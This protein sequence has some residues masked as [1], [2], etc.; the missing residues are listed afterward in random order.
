MKGEKGF[1]FN[2]DFAPFLKEK[3]LNI[4][5]EKPYGSGWYSDGVRRLEG[6]LA[7]LVSNR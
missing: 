5:R 1:K 7:F 3:I 4:F 6:S 2:L